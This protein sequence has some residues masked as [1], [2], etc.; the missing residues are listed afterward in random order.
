MP[1]PFSF[2]ICWAQALLDD[3][4]PSNS[5]DMSRLQELFFFSFAKPDFPKRDKS[6]TAQGNGISHSAEWLVLLT[7]IFP[8]H[9]GLHLN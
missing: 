1:L 7:R 9:L 5:A 2:A 3:A 6:E 4:V 8:S